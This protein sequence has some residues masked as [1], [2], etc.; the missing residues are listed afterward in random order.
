[1]FE[2]SLKYFLPRESFKIEVLNIIPC[3]V[4]DE[5]LLIFWIVFAG[6]SLGFKN[7]ADLENQRVFI[8]IFLLSNPVKS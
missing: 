3:T 7:T 6:L 4:G 8:K 2:F 5:A 1:M